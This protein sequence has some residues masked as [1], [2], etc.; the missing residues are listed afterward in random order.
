MHIAVM[1]DNTG[2]ILKPESESPA[3]QIGELSRAINNNELFL[4]YQPRYS[5]STGKLITVEALVRWQ[6]PEHGLL[7]PDSFIP[8]AAEVDLINTL[9][10]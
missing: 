4:Q 10:L 5:S 3:Y 9:G 1:S 6:H 7:Y 8:L 2:Q